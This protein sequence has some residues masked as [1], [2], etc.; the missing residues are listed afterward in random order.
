MSSH[1]TIYQKE[2]HV[3]FYH[4][5]TPQEKVLGHPVTCCTSHVKITNAL[6]MLSAA[7]FKEI[8]LPP[9]L[10]ASR[11]L[12][13]LCIFE[14]SAYQYCMLTKQ[15][16]QGG[17]IRSLKNRCWRYK[18]TF[19]C[20]GWATDIKTTDETVQNTKLP[21]NLSQWVPHHNLVFLASIMTWRVI[22]FLSWGSYLGLRFLS[23]E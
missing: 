19:V 17:A 20:I 7:W 10:I 9:F 5:Y 6:A 14:F 23:K 16:T 3:H 18:V 8:S 13:H 22:F 1:P 12:A 4:A 11:I 15:E 2:L 21:L